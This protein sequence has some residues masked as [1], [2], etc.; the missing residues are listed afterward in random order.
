MD[1][2]FVGIFGLDYKQDRRVFCVLNVV[3]LNVVKYLH[4]NLNVF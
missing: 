3:Y 2:H 1:V 4:T